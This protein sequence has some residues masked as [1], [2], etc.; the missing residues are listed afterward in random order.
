MTSESVQR[1]C[2]IVSKNL[3]STKIN[4]WRGLRSISLGWYGVFHDAS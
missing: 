1:L 3:E 2:W 4:S